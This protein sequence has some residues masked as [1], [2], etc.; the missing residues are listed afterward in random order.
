MGAGVSW[1]EG[2]DVFDPLSC[3][4][5]LGLVAGILL[6]RMLSRGGGE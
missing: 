2:N 6:Y 1:I 4:L 3:F 5:L